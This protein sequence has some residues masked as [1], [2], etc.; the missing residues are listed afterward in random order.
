MAQMDEAAHVVLHDCVLL[1][2]WLLPKLYQEFPGNVVDRHHE[3]FM[4]GRLD[5]K[6]MG[7]GV[8]WLGPIRGF[9]ISWGLAKP[10]RNLLQKVG[11]SRILAI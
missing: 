2:H 4:K 6:T 7:G 11:C 5:R 9:R 3:L 8:I 10:R 1:W